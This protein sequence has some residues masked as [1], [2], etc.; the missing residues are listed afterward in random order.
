[1]SNDQT[2]HFVTYF[3][4]GLNAQDGIL[5]A[6]KMTEDQPADVRLGDAAQLFGHAVRN[7]PGRLRMI[8]TSIQIRVCDDR[9]RPVLKFER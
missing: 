8:G 3:S 6:H 5:E 7:D 4:G 9:K 2:H 1:V